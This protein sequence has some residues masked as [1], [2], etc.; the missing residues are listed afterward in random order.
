MYGNI[1]LV[2]IET[3]AQTCSVKKVFLK[4]SQNLQKNTCAR[5][6][7]LINLQAN[8]LDSMYYPFKIEQRDTQLG[9]TSNAFQYNPLTPGV[10]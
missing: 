6:S 4:I 5:V 10:H 7:F 2:K 1:V 9:G 3:V 8:R